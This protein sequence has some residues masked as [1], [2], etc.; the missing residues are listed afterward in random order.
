MAQLVFDTYWNPEEIGSNASRNELA[1]ESENKG[2][3]AESKCFLL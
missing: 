3:Q 2:R 1:G